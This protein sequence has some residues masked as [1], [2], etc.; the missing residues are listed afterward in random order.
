MFTK[1]NLCIVLMLFTLVLV[2]NDK[3]ES[4]T[5]VCTFKEGEEL[6]YVM[7]YGPIKGGVANLTLKMA[8]YGDTKVYYAKARARSIGVT[9]LLYKIDDIY[10]SYFDPVTCK[11][12]KAIRNIS[13]G[14]YKYYNE[15]RF[16]IT[17][18]TLHSQRS[19][20][21]VVPDN[22]LDMVS[23][24]YYLRIQNL[25]D[26]KSG[27]VIDI[28]TYFGDEIFY[29]PIRYKGIEKIKTKVG[30]VKCYRFDPV[31][32]VGRVFE[33]EDDMTVWITADKNKIPI[34]VRFDIIVGSVKC[35]LYEYKNL[36][37]SIVA[38]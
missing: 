26:L 16:A 10:E 17:D 13:E 4:E 34:L 24:L 21:V 7:R 3:S 1:L 30:K 29:F 5:K 33:S 15:V 11:P 8:D 35:E 12:Y 2:A 28:V 14:G 23:L 38:D 25:E 37:T 32:E 9:D 22:I 31:V 18:S 36:C 27:D 6:T 19:G 20:E